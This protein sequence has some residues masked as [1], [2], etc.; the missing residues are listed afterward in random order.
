MRL[1]EGKHF[2]YWITGLYSKGTVYTCIYIH[3]TIN[4]LFTCHVTKGLAKICKIYSKT[5]S[6]A[7]AG[8]LIKS[9]F[10]D[11]M[12]CTVCFMVW[13]IIIP[14]KNTLAVKK[15]CSQDLKRAVMKKMWNQKG[16]AKAHVGMLL[17]ILKILILMTQA[18]KHFSCLNV[19][20]PEK[21]VL[22]PESSLNRLISVAKKKNTRNSNDFWN[23]VSRELLGQFLSNLIRKVMRL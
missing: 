9:S 1:L 4:P 18:T 16:M 2:S 22:Q 3:S 7:S 13:V 21:N 11:N 5:G 17:I 23:C 19:L 10:K 6:Q 14:T 15:S 8:R 20:R 12:K